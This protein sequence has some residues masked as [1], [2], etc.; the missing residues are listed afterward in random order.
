R[1]FHHNAN[2]D[3]EIHAV[4][5]PPQERFTKEV[6]P[7]LLLLAAAVG[8]TLLIA[9]V[10]IANLLLTRGSVRRRELA[11]RSALGAGRFR[12]VRQL[13]VESAMLALA[14]GA[15]GLLLA[16]WGIKFLANGLP[17]YLVQAN[18]RIATLKLDTTAL[19]FAFALS[20]LTS[21]LFGL[22]P[23]LQ[24]S[25]IDLHN[26]LK[27]GGRTAGSRNLL[28]PAL[29]VAEVALATVVLVGGGLMIKS[30]WRL[31]HVNLGY[32]PAG[33]LTAQIDPSGARY[34][35]FAQ[36]TAFYTDLLDRIS[37]IPGVRDAG[38]INSG[39]AS[40]SVSIDEHPPSAPGQG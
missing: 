33:V 7:M 27:E 11:I 38:I 35:E 4:I 13:L 37:T 20:L 36:V 19:G 10:N 8:F 21:V 15:V 6:R 40:F 24:L 32:E 5:R 34:K 16:R 23:A 1:E 28:R 18:S 17:E 29:V 12:I 14:G 39:N 22:I 30:F 31:A 3:M 9:C 25:K 2:S 26:T